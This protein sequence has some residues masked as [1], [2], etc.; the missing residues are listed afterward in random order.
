[1]RVW[2]IDRKQPG[3]DSTLE[4]GLRHLQAQ[5]WTGVTIAGSSAL[6]PELAE[7]LRN[8]LPDRLDA[9]VVHERVCS[10]LSSLDDVLSLQVG[11]L[12]A[13]APEGA[14]RFRPLAE[15]RALALVPACADPLTLW[16]ALLGL[17]AA[18]QREVRWKKETAHLQQRLADR[19]LIER[20]KGILVQ[21]LR[22]SEVEAYNRLR[23]LSRRQRRHVRD[24]AQSLLDAESLF[25]TDSNGAAPPPHS[26]E[27][28]Q[29]D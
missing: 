22:I 23:V 27:E 10:A 11:V 20:A 28:P 21:R 9:I 13:T 12:V 8:L 3:A 16:L 24:I 6:E 19:I 18:H 4:E 5:P 1:M 15:A 25:T 26:Q 17:V 14:A 2:L 29:R 7:T